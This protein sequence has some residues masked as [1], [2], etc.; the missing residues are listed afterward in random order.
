MFALVAMTTADALIACWDTKIA[1]NVWRPVTVS[2]SP[3]R[4]RGGRELTS[5]C[6]A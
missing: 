4:L 3:T 6:G 5:K 1:D 2:I